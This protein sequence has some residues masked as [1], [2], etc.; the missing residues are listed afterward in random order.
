MEK[1]L[2]QNFEELIEQYRPSI[3]NG[4]IPVSLI[5]LDGE[6]ALLRVETASMASKVIIDEALDNQILI[7]ENIVESLERSLRDNSEVWDEL[8]K[9]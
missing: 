7:R 3:H 6:N 9:H 5:V 2:I 4:T 1:T 8:S